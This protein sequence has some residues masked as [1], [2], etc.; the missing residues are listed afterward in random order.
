MP[1]GKRKK[2]WGNSPKYKM[3]RTSDDNLIGNR[4]DIFNHGND[5]DSEDEDGTEIPQEKIPPITVDVFHSFASV[6]NLLGK[7]YKYKRMSIGTKVISDSKGLYDQAIS[8][9][10]RAQLQF[11]THEAK[12]T[13]V[14]RLVLFG[15]PQLDCKTITEEFHNAHNIEPIS[16]KEIKT[17]RSSEDDAIYM[18]EFDR[19]QI[20][21]R[22]LMRIR[23]FYGISVK[24]R[25]P[26][27]GNRGPTQCSK[28]AMYGHGA[29]H[30]YRIVTCTAC[31]GSH[32]YSTCPL[33]KTAQEGPVIYK[34]F[35]CFK[36]KLK[37]INHRA[38]DPQCPCR[39]E[40]LEI[41]NRASSR[42]INFSRS[43]HITKVS[44]VNTADYKI[45]HA[46]NQPPTSRT[47]DFASHGKQT[48]A[49]AAKSYLRSEHIDNDNDISNERLLEIFFDAVDALQ[50]C[51]NKY[52][53]LR[54]LGMILKNAL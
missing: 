43:Q 9:L 26:I 21:K 5:F 13:K 19:E 40:Y 50:R 41:R 3:S 7:H 38:D 10:K 6:I 51:Q 34:C 11:F 12:N 48:Y 46:D 16:V 1:T 30:C 32:D 15:L 42:N 39:S 25:N 49:N 47:A 54:V 28:C 20:S 29:N 52:D 37:N 53:K 31:A 17:K 18:L 27:K 22:E 45:A 35:N 4:F 36:N 2:Y 24:W 44:N 23:F 8:T 33:N 14:F